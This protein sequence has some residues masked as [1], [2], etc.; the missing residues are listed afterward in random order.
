MNLREIIKNF[1][2]KFF[3]ILKAASDGYIIKYIGG[4]KFE[5]EKNNKLHDSLDEFIEH[6]SK[7]LPNNIK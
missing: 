5:F 2:Y 6:C 1:I 3:F 7:N 4:N